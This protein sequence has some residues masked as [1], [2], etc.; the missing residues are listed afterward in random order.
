MGVMACMQV[1]DFQQ[2]GF[3]LKACVVFG[4]KEPHPHVVCMEVDDEQAVAET[5]LGGDINWTPKMRGE[6][7]KGTGWF[8]ASN[9]VAWCSSGLVEEA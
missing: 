3:Q 4:L 5:M 1:L 6:V 9:S 7:E 2:N 8:R